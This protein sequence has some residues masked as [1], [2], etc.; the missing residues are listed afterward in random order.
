MLERLGRV[1]GWA[2]DGL[3]VLILGL[4]A[5]MAYPDLL[6]WVRQYTTTDPYAAFSTP[7]YTEN[8]EFLP[9]AIAFAAVPFLI[10]RAL[11]YILAGR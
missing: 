2:S 8:W 7:V 1:C 6:I 5:L 4:G 10:G 11:R 9:L 3:A